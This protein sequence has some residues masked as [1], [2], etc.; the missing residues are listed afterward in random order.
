LRRADF[1]FVAAPLT[2]ASRHL[3][4]KDMLA[5]AKTGAGLIN[6]GR[7]GV[8]DYEA[9]CAALTSGAL[10]GAVLDVFEQ[11]P[12]PA[13]SP[14]W[15]TPNLILMPHCSSDDSEHY[16]PLTLDLAFGNLQR[17]IDGRPLRNRVDP[18]RGY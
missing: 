9:L 11:E 13:T 17:L 7:A 6:V 14:L 1:I 12:L 10:S 3:L 15:T 16:M 8:V 5:A 4:G 18:A 2:P